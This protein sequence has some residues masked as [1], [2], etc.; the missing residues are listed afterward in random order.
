MKK[1]AKVLNFTGPC[2][3]C[4][5]EPLAR[6]DGMNDPRKS[7]WKGIACFAASIFIV[8][9]ALLV[10][11]GIISELTY[12]D[13]DVGQLLFPFHKFP[14][15]WSF[16][17]PV[18]LQIEETNTLL[19]FAEARSREGDAGPKAIG[20]RRSLD[21]GETWTEIEFIVRDKNRKP[22]YDG[23]NLGSAVYDQANKRVFLLYVIGA[24]QKAVAEHLIKHSNDT[25]HTWSDPINVDAAMLAGGIKMFMGGPSPGVQLENGRLLMC[26]WYN[27]NTAQKNGNEYNTGTALLAS[28]DNGQSWHISG[29]LPRLGKLWPNECQFI[30]LSNQSLLMNMRDANGR[31]S[32][33]RCR[34]QAMSHDN[35]DT[36]SD[37]FHVRDLISPVCQGSIVR[38]NDMLYFTNPRSTSK[39][40]NGVVMQSF[41]NGLHWEELLGVEQKMFGYSLVSILPNN[42]FGIIYEGS[43]PCTLSLFASD[44]INCI[45]QGWSRQLALASNSIRYVRLPIPRN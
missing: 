20:M 31:S 6:D 28:D 21:G 11:V 32:A 9:L 27:W 5:S 38:D 3:R 35:G 17:I 33:C 29:K 30:Q 37:P 42:T 44:F 25:G 12:E 19:A 18:L 7:T 16:R 26:G 8:V 4:G 43:T 14:D 22:T 40:E 39:R 2:G 15:V 36:W 10:G 23:L 41:D 34:L 1:T 13:S 24:H 45:I